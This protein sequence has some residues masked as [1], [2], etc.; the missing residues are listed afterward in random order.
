MSGSIDDSYVESQVIMTTVKIVTPF[1]LTYGLFVTF[2]GADAP[3]G[4]FQGGAIIGVVIL[5]LAFAFGIE[6]TREWLDNRVVTG[7]IAG[8][9]LAFGTIGVVPMLLGGAFLQYELLPIPHPTRYGIEGIEILGVA[10]IVSGTVI[11]LFFVTAAGFAT[12][13]IAGSESTDAPR[14]D[15]PRVRGDTQTGGEE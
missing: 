3:G 5:M 6:P 7:L 14:D 9:V 4:G 10:A 1:V 15:Q 11:S 12:E 13:A 8:G 2:H